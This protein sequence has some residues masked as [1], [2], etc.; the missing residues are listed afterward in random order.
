MNNSSFLLMAGIA[1][2]VGLGLFLLA[3]PVE[4]TA[5]PGPVEEAVAVVGEEVAA[6][7]EAGYW[8]PVAM[9]SSA[10]AG[11]AYIVN[12]GT[13]C[14]GCGTVQVVRNVVP[15]AA[16]VPCETNCGAP[17]S[18][19]AQPSIPV[20]PAPSPAM[21]CDRCPSPLSPCGE[22]SCG[23][24]AAPVPTCVKEEVRVERETLQC[25][26][27]VT[28]CADRCEYVSSYRPAINRSFPVCIDECTFVQLH[29]TARHPMCDTM[30][31]HWA[32]SRGHFVDPSSSDPIYYVPEARLSRGE[33]VVITL[34]VVDK[35][36]AE[37]TDHVVLHVRD[38]P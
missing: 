38:V 26:G 3:A 2:A 16:R 15:I 21:T 10:V 30:T 36:G 33:D 24:C 6:E 29:S 17:V 12:A 9:T 22:P 8:E 23:V 5:T 4:Q 34:L 28:P 1:I 11:R 18:P 19:C 27:P 37:Y 7:A 14:G 35:Y 25:P 31:F 32:A 13:P 20:C